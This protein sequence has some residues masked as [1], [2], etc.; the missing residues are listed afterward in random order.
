ME[1]WKTPV[2][3][4]V[5]AF[6]VGAA[7]VGF[8]IL[9]NREVELWPPK[10]HPRL[11][12]GLSKISISGNWKYRCTVI[13]GALHEW[14]GT[15][16]I[17]QETTPFGLQWKLNGQ[18]EW[19]R[20][21][22]VSTAKASTTQLPTPYPWESKWG[23]ITSEP[24]MRYGYSIATAKGE[25]DGYGYGAINSSQGQSDTIIGK[26]YQLPPLDPVHGKMEFR[27]MINST[28]TSW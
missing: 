21:V 15:A 18:R 5:I 3:L 13:G 12:S 6:I 24:A 1:K 7:F 28:D 10:I 17:T 27:R 16:I 2:W 22:D 19:E 11:N 20:T 26:F 9:D 4:I 25:I 8:G 14:G 23:I